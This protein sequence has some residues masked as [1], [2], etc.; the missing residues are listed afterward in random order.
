M[1]SNPCNN[2]NTFFVSSSSSADKLTNPSSTEQVASAALSISTAAGIANTVG[3]DSDKSK[4]AKPPAPLS[5]MEVYT[6]NRM[7]KQYKINLGI[8]QTNLDKFTENLQGIREALNS[9][10]EQPKDGIAKLERQ[11]SQIEHD[12]F[13]LS[14]KL[15]EMVDNLPA[16]PV[17]VMN[18]N[19][20]MQKLFKE[21]HSIG[22]TQAIIEYRKNNPNRSKPASESESKGSSSNNFSSSSKELSFETMS[23]ADFE[24]L[25]SD[26]EIK[27]KE[28]EKELHVLK[29]QFEKL[30]YIED[31]EAGSV[32]IRIFERV[33]FPFNEL[34]TKIEPV[35]FES[36]IQNSTL[37]RKLKEL[38]LKISVVRNLFIQKK[39]SHPIL[40][41][42]L[43][44]IRNSCYLNAGLQLLMGS[45]FLETLIASI[46]EKEDLSSSK[47]SKECE[48]KE[49]VEAGHINKKKMIECLKF[50]LKSW[51]DDKK[52]LEQALQDLR[53]ALDEDDQ[54]SLWTSKDRDIGGIS[55]QHDGA[56]VVMSLLGILGYQLIHQSIRTVTEKTKVKNSEM[57][58]VSK[59]TFPGT[60]NPQPLL[61]LQ[62]ESYE[63]RDLQTI[64]NRNFSAS[65]TK[66]DV[67]NVYKAV[68]N[69]QEKS[70]D[71]Y[72]DQTHIHLPEGVEPPQYLPVKMMRFSQILNPA[73]RQAK[74]DMHFAMYMIENEDEMRKQAKQELVRDFGAENAESDAFNE[75]LDDKTQVMLAE[76]AKLTLNID[77]DGNLK[78]HDPIEFPAN[79]LVDFSKIFGK[80]KAVNYRVVA[81]EMHLGHSPRGG[82][83]TAYRKEGDSWYY[84]D[85]KKV[86]KVKDD[87]AL[88]GMSKAYI[89]LFER[90]ADKK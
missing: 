79:G 8:I 77:D 89:L 62:M 40:S 45:K 14:L 20:T 29:E 26:F 58:S 33:L 78:I 57:E 31:E 60:P 15:Q 9:K 37:S 36:L 70:F 35:R 42:G 1:N 47:T 25:K 71:T 23:T 50:L 4:T 51:K 74:K 80:E 56:T 84:F 52:S 11:L 61:L 46:S 13:Q 48:K 24:K 69:G 81:F 66:K 44:N 5:K 30:K 54:F 22:D 32:E 18:L 76:H 6:E 43:P 87:K 16:N 2:S 28:I 59:F 39:E 53:K 65:E 63:E 73:E 12:L 55:D 34:A 64:L 41:A 68:I 82:H 7:L 49:T 27:Y 67:K 75:I 3:S 90:V 85:D 17:K 38:D 86:L 72:T 21:I 10:T 83:Y 88:E 19:T